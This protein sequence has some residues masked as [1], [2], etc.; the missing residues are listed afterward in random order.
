MPRPRP[1][2]F[3]RPLGPRKCS[4]GG[5]GGP[6]SL[7]HRLACRDLEVATARQLKKRNDREAAAGGRR[8]GGRERERDDPNS[9]RRPFWNPAD[10]P[11][12]VGQATRR[13]E[14]PVKR[15]LSVLH[16]RPSRIR[17]GREASFR[18]R[19]SDRETWAHTP[20]STTGAA[21]LSRGNIDGRS[22][23]GRRALDCSCPRVPCR[24]P[25]TPSRRTRIR[26]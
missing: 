17:P 19:D 23:R 15:G 3:P 1:D 8:R 14:P 18:T 24:D 16:S 21:S 20:L 12:V 10:P 11:L 7:R 22:F 6:S 5:G 4:A 13:S 26:R 2:N 9:V 25:V